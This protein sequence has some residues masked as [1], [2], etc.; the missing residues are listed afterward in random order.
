MTELTAMADSA[1]C[2]G[3]KNLPNQQVQTFYI[4]KLGLSQSGHS[5]AKI[6]EKHKG[7]TGLVAAPSAKAAAIAM[8]SQY[9]AY[10]IIKLKNA[11]I[12]Y[13]KYHFLKIP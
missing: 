8:P 1:I 13:V 9:A 6:S 10:G 7:I 3:L 12:N 4:V 11:I 5:I 2:Q